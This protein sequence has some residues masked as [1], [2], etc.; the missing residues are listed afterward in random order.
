MDEDEKDLSSIEGLSRG[1]VNGNIINE[2]GLHTPMARTYIVAETITHLTVTA[3]WSNYA[4]KGS[5]F[6][7]NPGS[8]QI[9]HLKLRDG[10]L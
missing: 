1:N 6:M 2:A 10:T 7:D 9:S 3:G 5:C 4:E 8:F